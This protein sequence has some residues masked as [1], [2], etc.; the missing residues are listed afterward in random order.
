MA[1]PEIV[2]KFAEVEPRLRTS[3]VVKWAK[4]TGIDTNEAM[5]LAGYVRGDD[6]GAGG[7]MWNYVGD[8]EIVE[9]NG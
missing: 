6:L 3:Y 2:A 9:K 7:F 1:D 8:S 5:E 4:E